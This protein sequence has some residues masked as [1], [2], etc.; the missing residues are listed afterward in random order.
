MCPKCA[1]FGP[2]SFNSSHKKARL[3]E[4]AGGQSHECVKRISR[5]NDQSVVLMS[6]RLDAL[7]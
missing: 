3:A 2:D 1:F 7:A 6:K 5:L 4:C